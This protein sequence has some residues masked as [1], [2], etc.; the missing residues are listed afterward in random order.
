MVRAESILLGTRNGAKSSGYHN[1]NRHRVSG[2]R[3]LGRGAVLD[4]RRGDLS[5]AKPGGQEPML[6]VDLGKPPDD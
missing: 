1:D 3:D 2:R 6:D 5:S 4:R